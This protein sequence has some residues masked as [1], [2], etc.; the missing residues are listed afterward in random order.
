MSDIK[1]SKNEYN[2]LDFVSCDS[3]DRDL[4]RGQSKDLNTGQVFGGQVLGQAINAA[5]HTV[6]DDREIR[7]AHA[8][9][10]LKG[11]VEAPI[12]YSIDRSLDGGSVSSRRVVAL[13]HGHQILHLS[14]SF[15]KPEQGL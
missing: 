2:L 3:L 12:I 14:S 9:F 7:S 6:D 11:D 15:Q 13:Q 10:L 1:S 4:F 5:Y 8:Y